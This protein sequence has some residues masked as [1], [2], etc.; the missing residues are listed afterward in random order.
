[1]LKV[2]KKFRENV[3]YCTLSVKIDR[4]NTEYT[5]TLPQ[6]INIQT[7]HAQGISASKQFLEVITKLKNLEN[8]D[9]S[10]NQIRTLPKSFLKLTKLKKLDLHSN[11]LRALPESFGTSLSNLEQLDLR[12]NDIKILPNTIIKL[13]KL[14]YLSL[15]GN[16]RLNT[17]PESF[18]QLSNLEQLNLSSTNI[19]NIDT[20]VL[21]LSNLKLLRIDD[22]P[23]LVSTI[24]YELPNLYIIANPWPREEQHVHDIFYDPNM[25]CIDFTSNKNEIVRPVNLKPF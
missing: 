14:N 24:A 8:L 22:K 5:K 18:E 10:K 15:S 23:E 1:M 12:N 13:S 20:L 3:I 16:R 4:W 2:S 6:L 21:K 11:Q 25:N 9:L 19:E 7:L 17:L